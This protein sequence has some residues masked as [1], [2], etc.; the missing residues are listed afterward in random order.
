MSTVRFYI[1]WSLTGLFM[2]VSVS[3]VS[4]ISLLAVTF[5]PTRVYLVWKITPFDLG[6]FVMTIFVSIISSWMI[7]GFQQ[8]L[9]RSLTDD[10][11]I[12]WVKASILGGILGGIVGYFLMAGV[13]Q[14]YHFF[15][16]EPPIMLMI[17]GLGFSIL[18]SACAQATLLRRDVEQ[19]WLWVVAH[20]VAT[21][22]VMAIFNAP[23]SN[24]M[25]SFLII[26]FAPGMITGFVMVWLLRFNRR[27]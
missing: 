22:V 19:S 14:M 7:G 5:L 18:G 20:I 15:L 1:L 12:G 27:S 16:D 11:W 13:Y 24:F 23:L 26:G 25:I 17:S 2:T 8:K 6:L 10:V 9:L 21:V 4:M 3:L